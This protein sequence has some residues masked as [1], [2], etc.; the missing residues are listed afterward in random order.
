[1]QKAGGAPVIGV[2][3]PVARPWRQKCFSLTLP[4]DAHT[5]PREPKRVRGLTLLSTSRT[6]R[7]Y[8]DCDRS[9]RIALSRREFA[10]GAAS[11]AG[12]VT[13]VPRRASA[14]PDY[15]SKPITIVA[16]VPPGGPTDALAR[17]V[18]RQ[19]QERFG[20]AVTIDNRTGAAGNVGAQVAARAAP[21]GYT[22]AMLYAPL[23]QNVAIY[24]APGYDLE[25]DFVPIATTAFVQLIVIGRTGL[26]FRTLPELIAHA[27]ANPGRISIGSLSRPQ[28]EYFKLACKIDLTVIPYRGAT[29][30]LADVMAGQIDLGIVPYPASVP[31]IEGG[32]VHGICATSRKRI[33]RLPDLVTVGELVPGFWM[34]SWYGVAA[35]ARTPDTVVKVLKAELVPYVASKEFG[36]FARARGLDVPEQP[37]EFGRT[38]VEEVAIWKRVV[39]ELKLPQI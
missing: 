38:I 5:L 16:P 10:L 3:G 39:K 8:A 22:L 9:D 6:G 1:M 14:R 20:Q 2:R 37:G 21:D 25:A 33:A 29:Q 26:P 19:L 34:H 13:L 7:G 12:A 30:T 32:K 27:T 17:M 28:A 31:H 4:G 11:V 24:K 15:P 36:E 18:A 35:P 23:A